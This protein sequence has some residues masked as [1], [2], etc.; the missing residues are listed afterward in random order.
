MIEPKEITETLFNSPSV[1]LLKIRQ[2]D[3]TIEFFIRVFKGDETIIASEKLHTVLSDFLEYKN[4]E[5]DEE[6]DIS[7]FDTFEEK[8]KKYIKNWTS[9]GFLT[10][11][12][13]NDEI[14]FELTS[15]TNKTID[16]LSSL[17][18]K[19]FVGAESKFK[20]IFNQ[21]K[22]LVEY[23][24]DD[25]EKRIEILKSK[26]LE[27]EHQIQQLQFGED[28]SVF[29]DYQIIE[30]FNN[31]NQSA[32]ELLSD[33]KEVEDNFKNITK[34]IYHKHSDS[35]LTKSDILGFTF[36][37]LDELKDSHQGKSFYA[38]WRFLMDRGLQE[39][40]QSLTFELFETLSQKSIESKDSFLKGMKNH[41]Y[42][43]GIK[44]TKANDKMAQKLS[45]IIKDN[46]ISQKQ[47]TDKLIQ[48]IKSF[49]SEISK[50]KIT[51]NLSI[52]LED[53]LY[54]NI[55]F[56]KRLTHEQKEDI[57]YSSIPI[58]ADNNISESDHLNKIF[59][60]DIIDKKELTNRIK[61]ALS[62]NS[63]TTL[64]DVIESNGGL[65]KGLPELFGYFSVIKDFTHNFNPDKQ[66]E[67]VF[68]T[69]NSKS[70]KIPEIILLK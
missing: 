29:E 58:L 20:D 21:L 7:V 1:E 49:L 68:D 34:E 57:V 35:N 8:A 59:D 69:K 40:W 32:K 52:E 6:S 46:Q 24:N 14:Y 48:E 60:K 18:K 2:R 22:E 31:L 19:E 9:K 15:H 45:R 23:T 4:I 41:L 12:S 28:V 55:P 10:N 70:I 56:E 66:Q 16:W 62:I 36:D 54:L 61:K 65:D 3:L 67:I 5:N 27:I 47:I 25:I 53:E 38:F 33:F 42:N 13:E 11:Y 17:K 51:P 39:Q 64:F 26:K 50:L 30:K 63:Q 44:V 43:S 37:A